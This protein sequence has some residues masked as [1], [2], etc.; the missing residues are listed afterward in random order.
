MLEDMLGTVKT[1]LSKLCC[2]ESQTKG[3][4]ERGDG[5]V[6]SG[7]SHQCAGPGRVLAAGASE[8]SPPAGT[9]SPGW[10]QGWVPA[11]GSLLVSWQVLETQCP[12]C[13]QHGPGV[14]SFIAEPAE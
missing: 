5:F 2:V 10:G 4:R 1:D 3:R 12:R 7:P 14:S 8:C 9:P 11:T 6:C 13:G